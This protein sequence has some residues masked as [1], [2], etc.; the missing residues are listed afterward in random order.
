MRTIGLP[1]QLSARGRCAP[2]LMKMTVER[3]FPAAKTSVRSINWPVHG[4]SVKIKGPG[5]GRQINGCALNPE[6]R[7]RRVYRL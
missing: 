3:V 2:V 6:V 4:S 5:G 1:R 7:M